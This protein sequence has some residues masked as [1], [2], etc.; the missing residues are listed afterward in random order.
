MKNK[1][2]NQNQFIDRDGLLISNEK[3]KHVKYLPNDMRYLII[4]RKEI[5]VIKLIMKSYHDDSNHSDVT[6]KSFSTVGIDFP[7]LTTQEIAKTRHKR[8]LYLL[9]CFSSRGVHLEMKF[10]LDTTAF[11]NAF[12]STINRRGVTKEVVIENGESFV[13][14]NKEF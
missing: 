14:V 13:T 9:T 6:S 5:P 7:F 10:G 11:L 3:M 8:Y 12:C 1:L 4:F 2:A